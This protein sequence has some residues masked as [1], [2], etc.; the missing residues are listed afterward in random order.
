MSSKV[1][2]NFK[3]R[4]NDFSSPEEVVNDIARERFSMDEYLSNP[5][6][7]LSPFLF[8][9]MQVAVEKISSAI[10]ENKNI[11]VWGDYDV[12]GTTS[13]YT[14]YNLLLKITKLLN[15]SSKIGYYIPHREKEG[16]GVNNNGLKK[17]RD[18]MYDLIISVDCGISCYFQVAYAKEIGLDFV[19]TDHHEYPSLVPDCPIINPHDGF[20][21]FHNLSGCGTAFKLMEGLYKYNNLSVDNVYKYLDITAISTIADLMDLN[22]ENRIIVKYGLYLLQ[23]NIDKNERPWLN[24]LLEKAK[25]SGPIDSYTVGFVIAPRIN[26]VGRLSHSMDSLRFM[27]TEDNAELDRMASSINSLNEERKEMQDSIVKIGDELIQN[28]ESGLQN[29]INIAVDGRVGVVGL[30]ASNLLEKY[31]RPTT[32]FSTLVSPDIYKASARSIDGFNYFEEVIEPNRDIIVGGGG[33]ALA[34]GLAIKKENLSEFIK[35][36]NIAVEK[37]LKNDPDLLVKKINIDCVLEPES[38]D[39]AFA[40]K[41][42]LLA[43]FG[44]GNPAPIFFME[45]MSIK[46]VKGV[47]A[48]DPKHVQITLVKNDAVFKGII[49]KRADLIEELISLGTIDVA[50]NVSINKFLGKTELNLIITYFRESK[51]TENK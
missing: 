19:V 12:D 18:D 49:F 23:N 22:G 16:Y 24:K 34:A 13:V 43:P 20:Y 50:F 29:S 44:Q 40:K 26:S 41:V 35:R 30:A 28:D 42:D 4:I 1:K 31:Y 46:S 14:T 5:S 33:H 8:K 21:P 32:V 36:V 45:N 37:C 38:I 25:F 48:T 51:I 6:S 2:L 47:P 27:L 15:S 39:L 10:K 9:D 3:R 17:L 7:L 11:C